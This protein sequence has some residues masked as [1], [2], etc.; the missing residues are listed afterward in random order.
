MEERKKKKKRGEAGSGGTEMNRDE[1]NG[2]Y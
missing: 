2:T 1:G